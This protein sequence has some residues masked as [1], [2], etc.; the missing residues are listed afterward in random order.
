M[1]FANAD[2]VPAAA[3]VAVAKTAATVGAAVQSVVADTTTKSSAVDPTATSTPAATNTENAG[4]S[5]VDTTNGHPLSGSSDSSSCNA[6]AAPEPPFAQAATVSTVTA[7]TAAGGAV[8]TATAVDIGKVLPQATAASAQ[9]PS[10]N[11]A[12]PETLAEKLPAASGSRGGSQVATGVSKPVDMVNL[13]LRAVGK[14]FSASKG[15]SSPREGI[16]SP[17][18]RCQVTGGPFT[19]KEDRQP[20]DMPCCGATVC[21]AAL[22]EV[23]CPL[24]TEAV[25]PDDQHVSSLGLCTKVQSGIMHVDVVT[26]LSLDSTAWWCADAADTEVQAVSKAGVKRFVCVQGKPGG[27][28]CDHSPGC[29]AHRLCGPFGVLP[30]HRGCEPCLLQCG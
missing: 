8:T 14:N 21:V 5:D 26:E 6:V 27:L 20:V 24:P 3:A 7:A 17:I 4:N 18:L 2:A 23:C 25:Y 12:V 22:K 29:P 19:L 11:T 15:K 30:L 28:Q 9:T 13:N 1:L 16:L 10:T